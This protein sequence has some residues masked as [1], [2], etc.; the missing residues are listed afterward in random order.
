M[1]EFRRKQ[2]NIFKHWFD[3][4]LVFRSLDLEFQINLKETIILTLNL[5][6]TSSDD[7][8]RTK[9]VNI[10]PIYITKTYSE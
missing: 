3:V 9:Y 6:L 1:G 10:F 5:N 2:D 7:I 4:S 8:I